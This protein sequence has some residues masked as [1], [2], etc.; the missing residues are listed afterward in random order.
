[1]DILAGILHDRIFLRIMLCSIG[2][3]I[4]G[5]C[6]IALIGY[7]V[8]SYPL[9]AWGGEIGMAIPTIIC[10]LLTGVGFIIISLKWNH[11]FHH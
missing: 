7:I 11:F 8:E 10:F 5:V 1:M 3:A 2:V 9:Y 6:I 4:N